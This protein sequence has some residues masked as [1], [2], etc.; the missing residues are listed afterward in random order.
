MLPRSPGSIGPIFPRF[1]GRFDY[2][3][4]AARCDRIGAVVFARIRAAAV[5]VVDES[6]CRRALAQDL[7][8]CVFEHG[9]HHSAV[10]PAR[11]GVLAQALRGARAERSRSAEG[12]QSRLHDR[13]F[14]TATEY[15]HHETTKKRSS[16]RTANTVAVVRL[17]CRD[18]F[19]DAT[20]RRRLRS[21][22]S[23]QRA[24]TGAARLG[25][26]RARTARRAW[27]ADC[28]VAVHVKPCNAPPDPG[29]HRLLRGVDGRR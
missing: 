26:Q 7:L 19:A 27:H 5:S 2:P 9:K 29:D 10:C 6:G 21:S 28:T 3:A 18:G 17:M 25:L 24:H 12:A 4:T 11:S 22:S 16:R 14:P 1:G 23:H 8:E 13:R 15:A 20:R